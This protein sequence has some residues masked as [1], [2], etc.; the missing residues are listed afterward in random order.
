MKAKAF[1][2]AIKDHPDLE[3]IGMNANPPELVIRQ[4]TRDQPVHRAIAVTSI[5]DKHATWADLRAVLLSEK[6]GKVLYHYSRIV[7]YYSRVDN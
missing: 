5:L 3:C 7:G 6:P 2:Q 4:T 1:L